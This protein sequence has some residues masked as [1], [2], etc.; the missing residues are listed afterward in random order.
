M[1]PGP[2]FPDLVYPL[3]ARVAP[4]PGLSPLVQDTQENVLSTNLEGKLTLERVNRNQSGTYGCRVEDFDAAED[5][6]LSQTLRLKVA[7]E[8]PGGPALCTPCSPSPALQVPRILARLLAAPACF[9]CVC[10][11]PSSDPSETSRELS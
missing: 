11:L 6:L 9:L 3:W 5:V 7:C 1:C 8:H 10:P 2:V 4:Q